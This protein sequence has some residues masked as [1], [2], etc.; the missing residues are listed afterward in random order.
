MMM[1]K[2][3]ARIEA[4]GRN[5]AVVEIQ[6]TNDG[7]GKGGWQL[8]D[9]THSETGHAIGNPKGSLAG[10]MIEAHEALFGVAL[11]PVPAPKPPTAREIAA[12]EYLSGNERIVGAG[13]EDG[14]GKAQR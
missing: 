7:Y 6:A 9:V 1:T 2:I 8:R 5:L 10:A 4:Q 12:V 3:V 11:M 13:P 14:A